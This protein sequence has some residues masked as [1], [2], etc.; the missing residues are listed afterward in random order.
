M[1]FATRPCWKTA[2]HAI[3]VELG[4]RMLNAAKLGVCLEGHRIWRGGN[5]PQSDIRHIRTLEAISDFCDTYPPT[6]IIPSR[7]TMSKSDIVFRFAPLLL[8][9]PFAFLQNLVA[10]MARHWPGMKWKKCGPILIQPI[11]CT[12]QRITSFWRHVLWTLCAWCFMML[13]GNGMQVTSGCKVTLPRFAHLYCVRCPGT[14]PGSRWGFRVAAKATKGSMQW[15]KVKQ[16]VPQ[17]RSG[18]Y[19]T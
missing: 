10:R 18:R 17:H 7:P 4:G 9:W 12:T 1:R 2:H 3:L 5:K 16:Q 8:G 13:H 19:L 11:W 6:R 15:Q 14:T